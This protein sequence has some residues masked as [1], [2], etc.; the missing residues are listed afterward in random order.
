MT[1]P[2]SYKIYNFF[3]VVVVRFNILSGN[4]RYKLLIAIAFFVK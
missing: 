2:I 3:G 4:I 1:E